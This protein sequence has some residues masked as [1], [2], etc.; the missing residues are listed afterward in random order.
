MGERDSRRAQLN[1]TYYDFAAQMYLTFGDS[2]ERIVSDLVG[3]G[4]D[5]A[6]ARSVMALVVQNHPKRG[7][8]LEERIVADVER[9]R[10]VRVSRMLLGALLCVGGLVTLVSCS[11]AAPGGTHVVAVGAI[12]GG[13]VLFSRGRLSGGD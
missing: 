1:S 13:A 3:M 6:T 11:V 5:E 2:P 9:K 10:Q 7:P 12:I 4:A 8:S